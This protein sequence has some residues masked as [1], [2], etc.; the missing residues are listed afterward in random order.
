MITAVGDRN[1]AM[2]RH[3][4]ARSGSS[5]STAPSTNNILWCYRSTTPWEH[6]DSSPA[7]ADGKVYISG[8]SDVFCWDAVTGALIWKRRAEFGLFSEPVVADGKVYTGSGSGLVFCLDA[9]TGEIIWCGGENSFGA[10][11]P[12]APPAVVEGKVYIGATRY[13][14][15]RV[16]K[17]FCLDALTGTLIWSYTEEGDE[18]SAWNRDWLSPAVADGKVYIGSSEKFF[19][20]VF[21]LDALT[22]TLI[23]TYTIGDYKDSSSFILGSCSSPAVV[24]GKVYMINRDDKVFCLDASS[25]TLISYTIEH[26]PLDSSLAVVDGKVYIGSCKSV[27]CLDASSG[28][29][30]WTYTEGDYRD[31][32]SPAV[33]DGKVYIGSNTAGET[34]R[35]K[36]TKGTVYCFGLPIPTQTPTMKPTRRQ[37]FKKSREKPR[38]QKRQKWL[39]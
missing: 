14:N 37:Q 33:A 11:P 18:R 12:P 4:I 20:K 35:R 25:G 36:G 7:V 24:E 15:E 2:F 22:G 13:A 26:L 21:C 31:W 16:N 5:S 29:L 27:F 28:T 6:F 34:D 10:Y 17:V 39:W 9:L 32:S 8:G 23:W 30:I 1:W 38:K 3:D 19:D